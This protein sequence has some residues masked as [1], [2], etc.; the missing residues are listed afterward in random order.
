MSLGRDG[1]FVVVGGGVGAAVER[2]YARPP[3][4]DQLE[5]RLRER[6]VLHVKV[7]RCRVVAEEVGL[8]DD[9]LDGSLL[10][11]GAVREQKGQQRA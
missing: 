1:P 2:V 8:G 11:G 7:L 9:A 5:H 3:R 6:C 10:R 4:G